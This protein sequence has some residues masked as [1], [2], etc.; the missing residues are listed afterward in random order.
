WP[1]MG[2]M[3]TITAWGSDSSA[4]LD[5]IRAGR[6]S[7]RLVD[8]LMSTYR[9]ESEISHLNS[10]AGE[11]GLHVSPQTLHVLLQARRFWKLSAGLFDPTVGPLVKAWGFHG[12]S[13][14]V[15]PPAEL[16]SLRGLVD[17]GL[18]EID[19]L[20]RT[21]RLARPG[22][23][24]DLGGIAKGYA[25]DLARAAL[26]I[27]SVTGG[28]IDL[29]GNVL[30]FGHPP[31]GH[32]WLIGIRHPRNTGELIGTIA[33]DSGAVATSG[34]YERYYVIDG[35][36]YSHIIDPTTGYPSRGVIAAS[37]FGPRGEWSDGV[38]AAMV[39]SGPDR[40]VAL[41]DSLPG[42]GGIFIT[43]LEPDHLVL[44]AR[45]RRRF[46]LVAKSPTS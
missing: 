5:A 30:V 12:D 25:L 32:Q 14:R 8:S 22:M 46:H 23:Q 19:S 17:Y 28:M 11:H 40:G 35:V 45:A 29:G 18:V 15:P 34:D 4:M 33:L 44:S 24:L 39:L 3:L 1:V 37:V 10:A 38:S 31:R 21:V 6:D 7:I 41:A 2:T 42:V 13:G 27:P 20:S 43:A 16:D 9:A 26:D 36:R